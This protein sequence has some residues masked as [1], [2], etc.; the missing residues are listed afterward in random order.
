MAPQHLLALIAEGNRG[1]DLAGVRLEEPGISRLACASAPRIPSAHEFQ[2]QGADFICLQPIY[3][4]QKF[5]SAMAEI[6][7]SGCTSPLLAEVLV[8][9]DAAT[10]EE[11][12]HEVPLLSVP[13]RLRQRLRHNPDEDSAG[14]LRFLRHWRQR[15]A[16][17]ML[18]LPDQRTAQAE[19]VLRGLDLPRNDDV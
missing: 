13:E 4:P 8:L 17:V 10:A 6:A 19:S 11:I 9:P 2:Q 12:N 14:V 7:A 16:G 1:Y 5:R 3:E 15:L 18:M